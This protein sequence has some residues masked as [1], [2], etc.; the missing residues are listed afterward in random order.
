MTPAS[1][2][3]RKEQKKTIMTT[4]VTNT[5]RCPHTPSDSEP[6][7]S[8]NGVLMTPDMRLKIFAKFSKKKLSKLH[9]GEKSLREEDKVKDLEILDDAL[10]DPIILKHEQG[11]RQRG[12][13]DKYVIYPEKYPCGTGY[14]RWVKDQ[15]TY[16]LAGG[17]NG[18]IYECETKKINK[19]NEKGRLTHTTLPRSIR[20]GKALAEALE[21]LKVLDEEEDSMRLG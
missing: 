6:S 16:Y 11:A 7:K 4:T 9:K 1:T 13:L 10:L 15:K 21:L 18:K 5:P 14:V 12:P 19:K 8:L 2:N 17:Y 20:V 3:F